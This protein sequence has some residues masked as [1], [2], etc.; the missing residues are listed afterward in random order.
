MKG[1]IKHIFKHVNTEPESLCLLATTFDSGIW[2]S[3]FLFL[4]LEGE[5][6]RRRIVDC[7]LLLYPWNSFRILGDRPGR[8]TISNPFSISYQQNLW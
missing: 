2:I 5:S 7:F 6:L 1:E 3:S 8:V 4:A